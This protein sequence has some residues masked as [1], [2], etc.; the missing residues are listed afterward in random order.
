MTDQL[1]NKVIEDPA[2]GEYE[3]LGLLGLINDE[4]TAGLR[5]ESDDAL[6]SRNKSDL[7]DI[8]RHICIQLGE[9]SLAIPLSA[10]LEAGNLQLLQPLPF[11]PDW[12]SGI[13]NIRGEIISVVNLALFLGRKGWSSVQEQP[14][15]VVHDDSIKTVVTVDKII[16]TRTL[17]ISSIE[18]SE[19]GEE[20]FFPM[21]FLSGKAIYKVQDGE[22]K[23]ELFDLH[24]FL[25]SPKLRDVTTA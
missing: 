21:E 20:R 16:G 2:A 7:K 1:V 18:Q 22:Q 14:F 4:L 23:I 24:S 11:L 6:P 9:E 10:V 19:Q 5:L 17:Y 8:G 15:L 12:L 13:T 25:S 3:L